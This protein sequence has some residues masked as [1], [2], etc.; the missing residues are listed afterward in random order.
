MR[1]D[2]AA[3]PLQGRTVLLTGASAGIGLAAA[4]QLA[5]LGAHLILVC[6]DAGRGEQARAAV[7][8]AAP[9]APAPDLLLADLAVQAEVHRL[10]DAILA[11]YPR[12]DVLINNAGVLPHQLITTADGHEL[13]WATNHL[14]PFIL[15]NRLLP[16]LEAAGPGARVITV[17]SE[18]HWIGEIEA[19]A[20]AR[21]NANRSSAF[22]AYC[23]SKLANILFTKALA[24]RLELTG[25]TAHCLHPGI[26]RSNL[27]SHSSWLL[28]LLMAGAQPFA[29]SCER[30]AETITY[31]ATLPQAAQANGHYFKNKRVARVSSRAANRA[32]IH[33]L[34]RISV[35]E[36]GVG[37]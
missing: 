31:L 16:L 23:D 17:A 37:E 30:A 10:S 11:R 8:L 21:A 32:E 1:V 18:A 5:L 15:T 29:R 28:R 14:A 3:G 9:R 33:R 12:L 34:W 36:T 22:T 13:C 4:R 20:A 24:D 2:S 35:E 19:T 6:R 7:R 26:V 27:W 25:I